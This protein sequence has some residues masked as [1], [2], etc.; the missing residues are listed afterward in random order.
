MLRLEVL[1]SPQTRL[2]ARVGQAIIQTPEGIS[3]HKVIAAQLEVPSVPFKGRTRAPDSA[4]K[5]AQSCPRPIRG[6]Q[7]TLE[8]IKGSPPARYFY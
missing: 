1:T 7:H 8:A 2:R 5:S 6:I 4:E 3:G